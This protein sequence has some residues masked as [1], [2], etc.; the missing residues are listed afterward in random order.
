M[1]LSRYIKIVPSTGNQEEATLFSTKQ[2]S[3]VLVSTNVIAEIEQS[4]L[5]EEEN[6]TLSSLGL[7]IQGEDDERNEMLAFIDDMNDAAKSFKFIIVLN[8]DCNLGCKY[9]YEGTRKGIL[10]LSDE[11]EGQIID[12]MKQRDYSNKDEI[13]VTF[14]GGEPLLSTE[15]IVSMSEKIRA[16][17]E[18]KGLRYSFTLVTNGTLLTS[19]VVQRL[20]PLGLMGAKV[21]LDGPKDVHDAFRPFKSGAGSFDVIVRNVQDVCDKIRIQIG[22]NFTQAHVRDFPRLLDYLL[23]KGLTPDKIPVVKFDPVA[24]ES[25]EFA[26]PD[27]H[28]GCDSPDEPWL[29]EATIY[30]REEILKR[31]YK[32]PKIAPAPCLMQYN[33]SFVVN[34]DGALYKCPGLMGRKACCIGDVVN[35]AKDYRMSH[36]LDDWKNEECLACSYLPLCFG[37]CKY[38]QLVRDNSMQGVNC[39]KSYFDKTLGD[40]VMQDIKYDL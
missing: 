2:A 19:K 1:K 13:K 38:M 37:G 23:D 6:E 35:G 14:Y 4:S 17:S 10:Y 21:T 8:L 34:Y 12:F 40:L 18:S 9:C 31:G 26:L 28:D 15:R 29:I 3:A 30:L 32:L 25:S 36:G 11:V 27:F 24:N 7:L 20:T 16:F 22:G 39:Q 5:S 33:E